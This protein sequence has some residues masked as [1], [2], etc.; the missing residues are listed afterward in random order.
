M[1]RYTP[2]QRS[3]PNDLL[4]YLAAI[5]AWPEAATLPWA[6]CAFGAK[7]TACVTAAAT[8]GG[9]A[10]VGFEN[11][12]YLPSGVQARDNAE[13]VAAGAAAAAD[14]GRPRADR[15]EERRVGKARASTSRSRWQPSQ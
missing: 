12:L 14:I 4:P 9:H 1:G 11:N 8:L 7:D 2:G 6:I 15:P 10:R 13:L 5:E 3:V